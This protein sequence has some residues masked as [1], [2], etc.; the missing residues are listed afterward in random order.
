MA[1]NTTATTQNHNG[2]GSQNNFAISFSFL[3][4]TEV[5][6]K[7]GGVLKTL[8]THYNIVGSEVQFT[9]GN[10]PPSGTA[11]IVLTR[12]TNIS[13][14]KVDFADGSVLTETDLDNNSDQIL[15]AQQE[16]INDFV[17]RDGTQTVTGNLVFEGATDDGNE[18]TLAI[19]DPTADRTITVPDRSGTIITSGDTGT[20][21]STMINDG[22]I[23]NADINNSANIAGTK[24]ADD[25]VTLAKLGS[26]ELP[27]DI[28]VASANI[29]DG[30]IVDGDIANTTIT[31]GKLANDTIT[32]TQIGAN[33]VTASE[34][35]DNAVD[36]NAVQDDAITYSKIQNVSATNRILGRDSSGAGVIE[37]ITPANLRTMINVEDGATADQTNAEIRAAVE[38][39]S[40]SNVFTDA[41]HS[42]LNGIEASAD[43]TDAT[44]VNAAGAVM[45]SDTSTAAMQF[46][47][48]EDNFGSNSDTKIPTQQSTKAYIA[49]TSQPLD[50]ELT[51]LSSMP[52]ATA[53]KL[54]DSTA[55]TSDIA[56]LNQ[57]DGMAKQTTIT[58]DDT[59]F[60]T[61]GA[62]VDFVA[63]QLA[64]IGGLEVI[65]TDAAFPNTQP[66]AGVV[67]SIAD[68]GGLVVNGSGTSTTGRTVGGSTVTI[69]NF[70]SNFN[71]STVDNGVAVMV[72]ST[73]S[74]QVYNY[75]KATLK[76]ADLLSLS[77]DIN[78]FAARYRVTNG[79]PSSN[80]DEG[81][82]IYDKQA[83]KMKV[84]DSTTN[85]F[86][87]VTSVGDFKFL[88]LCPAGGTGSP[89]FNGSIATYDLR[90]GSNSGSAASVTNA[91]QLIVSVDGVIQKPNTGTSAPSEGFALV[92]SNTIIFGSN[93]PTG[94]EVFVIQ[95]GS[96]VSLQVPA[97]N[98]VSSVKLQNGSVIENK[99]ANNAVT[100]NKIANGAVTVN[101][102]GG[103]AVTNAKLANAAVGAGNLQSNAVE[104]AKIQDQAVTLAKLEHGT[105][106]NNGKFLRANNGADPTFETVN[107][108]LVA[109]TSPQLGGDLQSNGNNILMGDNDEIK[110]GAG[111]GS[112]K[113]EHQSSSGDSF[114]TEVGG[115]NLIIQGSNIIIRDAGN[116]E[117]H[118]EMTQNGSVDLYNNGDKKFET[119][120]D[121]VSVQG[122]GSDAS[123]VSYIK[124][125]TGNGSHRANI[126]KLS[127]T[128]GALFIANLDNDSIIFRTNNTNKL[129]LQDAGH[130][131]P[132]SNNSYDLGSTSNRWANVYTNDLNL[133][134]EGGKNDV[135]GTWGSYTIQEGEE[136]LFLINKRNG[137]K[138]KF[139]LTEVS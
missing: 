27:T 133:S 69:N 67:I 96:A 38:A 64:P 114:I 73:G 60:P 85:A 63:A 71:S 8:G 84:F 127:S 28:T 102:L 139:N 138:Y 121:H 104:T 45:N 110:L 136:S 12:D 9:A 31:G 130:L 59:K 75:H 107:T 122:S 41:D 37:E 109:D 58:D 65:A 108:D 77:N 25:S 33:A 50:G 82:L 88:F 10:T 125:K 11:N 57:I 83:D 91:A 55:L 115:G 113:L 128:N 131:I 23:V 135:D 103:G 134:N 79:E 76:E 3:A 106:S 126:G 116:L 34:L 62:V 15:F 78:D 132:S 19:T 119:G 35:A 49:A 1:T 72:S 94:T 18:T 137:K 70:A 92:D 105:S 53:S 100:T 81:D 95:I 117:K 120:S 54:A 26:G 118:I 61:S 2:T 93:L 46:V 68:A 98:T 56:D 90:E 32:S 42:K 4:N 5:D 48:D 20:V 112:L 111:S 99:I 40:D 52:S 101:E 17:K 87:E 129:E 47:L 74:G 30:T 89:T 36:T 14:K 66:Q 51:T 124:F 24:L 13:A 80:N 29:V 39:A 21:T 6:V 86:K 97:D 22:T 44:N 123:G 7:V 16:I 43:V